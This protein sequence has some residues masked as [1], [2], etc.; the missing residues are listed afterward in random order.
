VR[1]IAPDFADAHFNA[2]MS[3]LTLGDYRRGFAEYEWRWE[4]TG[5]TQR[6]DLRQ[7]LW[8]GET[9]LAGKAILLHAEQG[10]GDTLMFVRY[11]SQLTRMGAKV[12]LEVQP[13]L[14]DLLAGLDGVTTIVTRGEPL[15]RHELHCPLASL[16]LAL[17]TELHSIPADIPYLQAPEA[18]V[19]KW[20]PRIETLNGPRI[21]LAWSGSA[22]HV[23]DK[24][25]SVGLAQL[26]PLLSVPGVQFI[27]VQRELR[28]GEAERLA[29]D[30]RVAHWGDEL[31]DFSDTAAVLALADLAICIDSS[32][33]HLAGALGRPAFV[34][35]PLQP[36]WRWMLDRDHSPWYP[37]L[38]LFRQSAP[39]DW[40][41][42]IGRVR[43]ELHRS[44]A[45]G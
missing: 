18:S 31:A 40:A 3:L 15:P 10:L 4:R 12:A 11:V 30:K 25:R 32:V 24:R 44:F 27:S 34:L 14:K 28:D 8:L 42:V 38:R 17:T 1:Q 39:G 26:E 21:A 5:M 2:A 6:K 36:D 23:N 22:S 16:P 35:L 41:E 29:G 37:A 33:A 13:E 9:P 45:G 7:P 43:G 19:A 20:R